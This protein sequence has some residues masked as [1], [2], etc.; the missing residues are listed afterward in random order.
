[1]KSQQ[2]RIELVTRPGIYLSSMEKKV[3]LKKWTQKED[4]SA[5]V[6]SPG[7]TPLFKC[8]FKRIFPRECV[9]TWH[10]NKAPCQQNQLCV[11]KW[12]CLWDVIIV[13]CQ[14]A[15]FRMPYPNTSRAIPYFL[16][17]KLHSD[18]HRKFSAWKQN[19]VSCVTGQRQQKR[20]KL[21]WSSGTAYRETILYSS[22][23]M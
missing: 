10:K 19:M 20:V 22:F 23:V 21:E 6:R 16:F 3:D 18:N 11:N 1:M 13:G 12:Y 5:T 8:Y 2:N 15:S 17:G 7:Q 9:A 14:I 4:Q